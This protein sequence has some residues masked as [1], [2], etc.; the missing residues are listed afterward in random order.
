MAPALETLVRVDVRMVDLWNDSAPERRVRERK[1]AA[2]PP[3]TAP[4]G[5]ELSEVHVLESSGVLEA[6]RRIKADAAAELAARQSNLNNRVRELEDRVRELEARMPK[7]ISDY[8]P[9]E[10]GS[11]VSSWPYWRLR[12]Q[13]R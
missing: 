7:R 5:A 3:K 8:P 1:R 11:Y 6:W 10:D 4:T 2:A 12:R 13:R 9:R